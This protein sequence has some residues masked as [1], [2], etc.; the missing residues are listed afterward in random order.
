MSDIPIRTHPPIQLAISQLKTI[1]R[2]LKNL[3]TEMKS[4][5]SDISYIKRNLDKYLKVKE[6]KLIGELQAKQE[7]WFIW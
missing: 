3:M 1:D 7:G 2:D 5:K 6:E 4:V